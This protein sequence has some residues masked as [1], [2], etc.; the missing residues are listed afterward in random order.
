MLSLLKYLVLINVDVR[1]I[2]L[3][4]QVNVIA[5]IYIYSQTVNRFALRGFPKWTSAPRADQNNRVP[6]SLL[7]TFSDSLAARSQL[8]CGH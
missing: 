5:S 4:T 1:Q 7:P 8:L 6:E 3:D 2:L